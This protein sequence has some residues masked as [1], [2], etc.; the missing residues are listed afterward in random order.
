MFRL[1]KIQRPLSQ[2]E[3]KLSEKISLGRNLTRVLLTFADLDFKQLKL[4]NCLF[5]V[6]WH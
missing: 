1:L 5:P 6:L 4:A 3:T 2:E